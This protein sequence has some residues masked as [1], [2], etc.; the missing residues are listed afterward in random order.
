MPIRIVTNFSVKIKSAKTMGDYIALHGL[1]P[2]NE[3][4]VHLRQKIPRNEIWIR[5]D[6]YNN[7][8]R[9]NQILGHE[10]CELFLMMDAGLTYKKAHTRA[11]KWEETSICER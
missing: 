3:L 2:N 5:S 10:E 1:V 8:K 6:V 9:R 4:P 11:I 7:K